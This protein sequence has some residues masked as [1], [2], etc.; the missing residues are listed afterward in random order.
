VNDAP[1]ATKAKTTTLSTEQQ[2]FVSKFQ[3][4]AAKIDKKKKITARH[5]TDQQPQKARCTSH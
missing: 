1:A 3:P 2:S 4:A 5:V